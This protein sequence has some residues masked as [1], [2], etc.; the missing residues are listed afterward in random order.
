MGGS[1]PSVPSTGNGLEQTDCRGGDRQ[2][3]KGEDQGI[4][5]LGDQ[6]SLGDSAR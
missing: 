4:E 3:K 1:R 5:E 2:D 6:C